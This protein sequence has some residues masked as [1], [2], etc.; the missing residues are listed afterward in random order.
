MTTV[1]NALNARNS[2][3]LPERDRPYI[4]RGV[5]AHLVDRCRNEFVLDLGDCHLRVRVNEDD[6]SLRPEFLD[7]TFDPRSGYDILNSATPWDG[8]L[9]KECG[10]TWVGINQQGYTDSVILSFAGIV[11]T[12]LLHV[13]ASSIHVFSIVPVSEPFTSGNGR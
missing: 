4:V 3:L 8:V 7:T 13:I 2:L 11:P 6:D 1:A 10:W 9:G 12:V 5:F